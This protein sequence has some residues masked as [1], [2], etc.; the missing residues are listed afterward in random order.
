MQTW[1]RNYTRPSL[2]F[3]E[4]Q[5][6]L[7]T[8]PAQPASTQG[9]QCSNTPAEALTAVLP[10]RKDTGSYVE[11]QHFLCAIPQ[12]RKTG[13]PREDPRYYSRLGIPE[14]TKCLTEHQGHACKALCLYSAGQEQGLAPPHHPLSTQPAPC[15]M[16]SSITS[17]V[18]AMPGLLTRPM[19]LMVSS[20]ESPTTPV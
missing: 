14:G 4:P 12:I 3:S 11:R 2:R 1:P 16:I 18:E 17:S 10:T 20:T 13:C 8:L 5:E 9:Q 6:P 15:C 7:E 19:F